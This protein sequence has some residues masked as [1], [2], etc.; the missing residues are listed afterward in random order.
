MRRTVGF[1]KRVGAWEACNAATAMAPHGLRAQQHSY[2]PASAAATTIVRI[3]QPKCLPRVAQRLPS[4]PAPNTTTATAMIQDR[5][6]GLPRLGATK[7]RAP[8]P[9]HAI[10]LHCHTNRSSSRMARAR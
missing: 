8:N 7:R 2:S 4:A 9:I 5:A 1:G 6:D 10:V 3:I